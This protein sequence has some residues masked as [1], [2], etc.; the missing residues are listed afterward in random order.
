MTGKRHKYSIRS[1]RRLLD[2]LSASSPRKIV[3]PQA[4]TNAR[5]LFKSCV[6]ENDLLLTVTTV[7]RQLIE[8]EFGGLP[9]TV[10][11]S[12]QI[13]RFDLLATLLKLNRYNT[14]PFFH[15]ATMLDEKSTTPLRAVIH[16]NE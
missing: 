14:F 9:N 11:S 4:I 10:G 5:R 7:L 16:V 8:T 12:W 1:S 13:S 2:L 15:V 6:D 3:R